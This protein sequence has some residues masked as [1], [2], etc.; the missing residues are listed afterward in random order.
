MQILLVTDESERLVGTI[1]DGDIRRAILRGLDTSKPVTHVM[2]ENPV[3]VDS[4]AGRDDVLALMRN[5]AIHC[6]PVI[7][8]Q[9][10]IEGLETDSNLIWQGVEDTWV[11]LM[12]GGLGMR[13]RPLT[14]ATP[15]PLLQVNGKPM[16]E[17]ILERFVEQG[18]RKFYLSV[19]Y[20]AE[21]IRNH[22]GAC[23]SYLDENKPLGTGGAL[24]LLPVQGI[25]DNII[26]MNGDLLTT[27]NFRHLLAFHDF[28]SGSATMCVRDY[29]IQVPYGVVNAQGENFIDI[30]EKPAHNYFVNAGVYVLSSEVLEIVPKNGFFDLPDLFCQL[31]KLNKK[32]VV[33]PL[34]EYWRDIGSVRDYELANAEVGAESE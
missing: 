4:K 25:S 3:T 18:F 17:H 11:V 12:A 33:F 5:K 9:R 10:R 13:L 7:D 32:V 22:F 8:N 19:N 29:S 30:V 15:K 20:K 28:H 23:I 21:M 1:T 26:V 34:R 6:V 16:L 31:K 27:L 14:Q 2:N 24:S